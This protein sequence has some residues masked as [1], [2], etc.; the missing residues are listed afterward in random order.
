[1]LEISLL[2]I[3]LRGIPEGLIFFM[4]A[5]AIT[6]N[7]IKV[8]R[9]LLSTL[10]F[11]VILYLLRLLPINNGSVFI[12]NL[13]IFIALSVIINKFDIVQSIKAGI[14]IM[15]IEF[16]SEGVNVFLIQFILKKDLN[17][18]LSDPISKL[19]YFMPSLFLVGCIVVP[20]YMILLKRKELK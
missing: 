13:I 18:I 20:Y 4:A 15:L 12:L 11:S 17:Y 7:K 8:K 3:I 2:E 16:I 5:H 6:K 9:Y 19:I 10:L 1:M 14:M